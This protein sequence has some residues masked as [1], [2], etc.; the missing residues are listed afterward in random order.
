[1]AQLEQALSRRLGLDITIT[2]KGRGGVVTLRFSQA[3]QL[4]ALLA[5]LN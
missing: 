1:L 3:E 5:R 4:D 2:R